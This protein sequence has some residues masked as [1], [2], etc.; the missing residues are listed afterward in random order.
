MELLTTVLTNITLSSPVAAVLAACALLATAYLQWKKVKIEETHS[1]ATS[2]NETME[3]LMK[4][5]NVLGEQLES[6]RE[7][8]NELHDRNI[9]LMNRLREANSKIAE[10]ELIL[11]SLGHKLSTS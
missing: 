10:L 6:T 11:T 3:L 9:D 7:Q 5:I 4:Q 2:H 8:L 1:Y